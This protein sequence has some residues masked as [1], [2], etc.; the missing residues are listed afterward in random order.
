MPSRFAAVTNK[1]ISNIIKQNVP[2]RHEEGVEVWFGS[3]TRKALSFLLEL[4]VKP[5][6]KFF[7]YKYK[8]GL[9]LALLYLV[10]LI[11]NKLKTKF[12]NLF[13]RVILRAKRIHNSF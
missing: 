4:S 1:E 11:I 13:Y 5:V 7:V 12:N 10:Y 3:L 8:L 2:E 6:K 9:S